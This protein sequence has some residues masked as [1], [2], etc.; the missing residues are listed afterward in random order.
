MRRAYPMNRA[1]DFAIGSG[2]AGLALKID[3]A[4]QLY[5]VAN[6]ILQDFLAFDDVSVFEPHFTTGAEPKIFRWRRFHEIVP[7]NE[8]L[9]AEWNFARS[10][11]WIFGLVNGIQFFD[12]IFRIIR[13]YNFD[14][15]QHSEP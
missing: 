14:G 1:F 8:K 3:A 13:E 2:A 10:G 6:I 11:I 7:L 5:H 12:L 9:A 4:A 15:S